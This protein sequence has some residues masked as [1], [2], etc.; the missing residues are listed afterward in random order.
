M[1]SFL[2]TKLRFFRK[3]DIFGFPISFSSNGRTI[4]TT[5][6]GGLISLCFTLFFLAIVSYSF[7]NLY[8][9]K[10]LQIE[11]KTENLGSNYGSLDLSSDSFMFAVKT[12]QEDVNTWANPYIKLQLSQKIQVRESNSSEIFKRFSQ[13]IPLIPCT[14]GHFPGLIEEF[15]E[16]QFETALCPIKNASLRV[17]G[18]FTEELFEYL[19]ISAS[20]C[21][22]ASARCRDNQE[23]SEKI[24]NNSR[25]AL[26]FYVIN[27]HVAENSMENPIIQHISS[28]M[29]FLVNPFGKIYKTADI[30]LSDLRIDTDYSLFSS[31]FS[32]KERRLSHIFNKEITE[33]TIFSNENSANF[34]DFYFRKSNIAHVYQRNL[35]NFLAILSYLGGI[36]S[37]CYIFLFILLKVYNRNDFFNK[38]GNK[39]Y[40]YPSQSKKIAEKPVKLKENP[41]VSSAL[42]LNSAGKLDKIKDYL[43][44]DRKL[45]LGFANLVTYVLFSLKCCFSCC[46]REKKLKLMK[47]TEENLMKDLDIYNILRKLYEFESTKKVLFDE[48][49]TNLLTF[50][51]KPVIDAGILRRKSRKTNIFGVP[52]EYDRLDVFENLI[53]D[54]KKLKECRENREINKRIVDMFNC[55]LK[56]IITEDEPKVEENCKEADFEEGKREISLKISDN[57]KSF[58]SFELIIA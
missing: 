38:L 53:E 32:E 3:F 8:S 28:D 41:R 23:F 31:L 40:N 50:C 14:P 16:Y 27:S 34:G 20:V 33:Q 2:Y 51:P 55:E 52:L 1:P 30:F 15:R 45:K 25:F 24:A 46:F 56:E 4:H 47:K 11:Y 42:S 36:W 22:D 7:F 43:K 5:R 9:R 48:K 37:T 12:N 17:T 44:Y 10:L 19:K 29:H 49:Q 35:G 54:Y 58:K 18:G 21:E 57:I 13:E 6:F 39:L 26:D